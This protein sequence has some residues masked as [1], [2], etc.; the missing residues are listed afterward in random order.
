MRMK[1]LLPI[2]LAAALLLTSCAGADSKQETAVH[3]ES[4]QETITYSDDEQVMTHGDVLQRLLQASQKYNP[5]ISAEDIQISGLP[6]EST[7]TR[8]DALTMLSRAFGTLP[9][10]VGDNARSG[11]PADSFSDIREEDYQALSNLFNTGIVTGTSDTAFS[12]DLPIT[13]T[14][15]ELLIDRIYAYLGT[16]LKDDFYAAINREWLDTCSLASDVQANSALT[17]ELPDLVN[18]QVDEIMKDAA[19]GMEGSDSERRV[20]A[21]YQSILD[22]DTRNKQGISPIQPYLDGIA[23]ADDMDSLMAVHEQIAKELYIDLLLWFSLKADL[24]DE[25]IYRPVFN[26]I[27]PNQSQE[28]YLS[29]DEKIREAVCT[30]YRNLFVLSGLSNTEAEH[31]ASLVWEAEKTLG[32]AMLPPGEEENVDKA[33]NLYTL[34]KLKSLYP[35]LDLDSLLECSGLQPE[36]FYLVSDV[37]H[38]EAMS[39]LLAEDNLESMKAMMRLKLMMECSSLLSQDIH[40]SAQ[41]FLEEQTGWTDERSDEEIAAEVVKS[42]LKCDMDQIYIARHFSPEAKADLENMIYEFIEVYKERI[43]SLE[44]MS[45]QTRQKALRKLETMRVKVGYPDTWENAYADIDL[46]APKDGGS[47]FENAILLRKGMRQDMAR[48]QGTTVDNDKWSAEVY[49]VN[50]YYQPVLNE[51]CFPA[52]ILRA[53]LYDVDAPLEENLGGIGYV[54]A[55]E[56]THAF[57]DMGAKYDEYGKEVNWWTKEDYEAFEALCKEVVLYY[58]GVESAPGI[59]CDGTLTLSENIADLGAVACITDIVGQQENPN[60]ELL[61]SSIARAWR[62]TGDREYRTMLQQMDVHAPEKLRVNRVLQSID[63]FY[64]TF[65]IQPGDNMYLAPEERVAIW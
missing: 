49:T 31:Q 7:L 4:E 58:D 62:F 20:S 28:V 16:D 11:F 29:E 38:M 33:K 24:W 45:E 65:D 57:D 36:E 64:D 53:P 9:E 26:T 50:A 17:I 61:F 14:E 52:G 48:L 18:E 8:I 10:P 12:P 40:E 2:L 41:R 51:I 25:T 15:L 6:M 34:E 59:T 37:G 21:L 43:K 35:Q 55:H 30:Y 56:I 32:A 47:Y 27:Y 60:Y 22:W 1:K 3:S 42:S 19:A 63:E 39:Q 13:S 46:T 23:A 5:G 54:I 44:W